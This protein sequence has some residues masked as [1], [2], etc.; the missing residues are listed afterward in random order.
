M[1]KAKET[2]MDIKDRM[3]EVRKDIRE[4]R[5]NLKKVLLEEVPEIQEEKGVGDV[6][7]FGMWI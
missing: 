3:N 2:E 7:G 4:G 5:I 6:E 1:L